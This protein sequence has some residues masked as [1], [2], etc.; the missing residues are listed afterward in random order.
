ML[1]YHVDNGG[2]HIEK[3]KNAHKVVKAECKEEEEEG[4]I[5]L[6]WLIFGRR[7]NGA[8]YTQV[9]TNLSLPPKLTEIH[10]IYKAIYRS[11]IQV[12]TKDV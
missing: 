2:S 3:L 5:L 4:K 12:W 6:H 10:Y 1:W 11:R 7:Y 9:V 8:I